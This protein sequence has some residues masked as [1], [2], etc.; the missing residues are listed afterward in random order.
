MCVYVC[1][2]ALAEF[3]LFWLRIRVCTVTSQT[4]IQIRKHTYTHTH[5]HTHTNKTTITTVLK[6]KLLS[7]SRATQRNCSERKQ[8]NTQCKKTTLRARAREREEKY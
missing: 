2:C 3:D 7:N 6:K 8:H 4:T 1:L 5:T